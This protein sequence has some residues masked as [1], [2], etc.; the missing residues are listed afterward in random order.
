MRALRSFTVEDG[1]QCFQ[2]FLCLEG[3]FVI[4]GR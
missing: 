2:P 3:V 1:G 4:G